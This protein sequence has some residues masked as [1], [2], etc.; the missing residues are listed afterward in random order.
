MPETQSNK[1]TQMSTFLDNKFVFAGKKTLEY[2]KGLLIRADKGLHRD[3]ANVIQSLCPPG[4]RIL[5]M[6]AGQG[7]LSLRLSEL[8]YKV[9]A[10]DSNL[11]DFKTSGTDF[12]YELIDFD[13][14]G[15]LEAFVKKNES[16]FDAVLGIEVI[17]HLENPWSY[18]RSL[19]SLAKPGGLVIVSTPHTASWLT[20]IYYLLTGTFF[21]FQ[22]HNLS[23]GHINPIA[24][25]E[26]A[27]IMERSGLI[28]INVR[29]AGTLPPLYAD[30]LRHLALSIVGL[31]FRPFQ[32]GLL[33]GYCVIAVGEKKF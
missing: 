30:S 32:Q 12:E 8:G 33:D 1:I 22:K 20:R 31:C 10:I 5:D 24:P 28:N 9:K 14:P 21:G 26:L 11:E 13:E 3:I 17:E 23:Y 2:Y 29:A 25:F 6:G 7:A 15:A 19:A 16:A 27:L 4:S 18:V